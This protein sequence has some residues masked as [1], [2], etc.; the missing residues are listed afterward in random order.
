[1]IGAGLR[2]RDMRIVIYG[3]TDQQGIQACEILHAEVAKTYTK[4]A[5]CVAGGG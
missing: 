5:D 3:P 2:E 4:P 1:V